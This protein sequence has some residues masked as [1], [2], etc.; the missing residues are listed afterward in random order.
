MDLINITA[1]DREPIHIPGAI[2][3]HGLLLVADRASLSVNMAAGDIEGRLGAGD[4]LFRPL[5]DFIGVALAARAAGAPEGPA[6]LFLGRIETAGAERLDVSVHATADALFVEFEPASTDPS[7]AAFVLSELEAA[8][9][10]FQNTDNIQELC[11]VAAKKFRALTGFDRVMVYRFLDDESGRVVAESRR[12]DLGSFLHHHFP[13]SDIPRQARALYVRNLV[14]TIPTIDYQAAPLRPPG[15]AA[16]LDM[17]DCALRSVSP[18]HLQYLR[19]MGV[20]ASASVSIVTGGRLWGLIACHNM[21]PLGL[22]HDARSVCRALAVALAQQIKAR[23]ERETYREQMRLTN[24]SAGLVEVLAREGPLHE[25]VSNHLAELARMLRSDGVAILRGSDLIASGE[26]PK[27]QEISAL[28]RWIASRGKTS[29]S[30]DR[31]AQLYPEAA[32]YRARAS[33]VAA[34]VL[35]FEEPWLILWFRAEKIEIVKWAGNPHKDAQAGAAGELTPRASFEMWSETVL[36]RARDWSLAEIEAAGR[37]A[38][39][40]LEARQNWRVRDLNRRLTD[41]L[42]DKDLLLEQKQYLIGEVNH[43]VQNSLQLV[44][45]FLTLQGMQSQ[46]ANL[47]GSIDEANRRIGAVALLHR[48]LYRGDQI[49]IVELS[50]YFEEL[51]ADAIVALGSGWAEHITLDLAP[52]S[53]ST[54]QAVVLGLILTEL[55]INANKYAYGG[56]PGPVALKLGEEHGRLRLVLSDKGAGKGPAARKGFGARMLEALVS[57]LGGELTYEDNK[58]GLR[59]TLSAPLRGPA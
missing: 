19:N 40:V 31:L 15:P 34:A 5:S 37:L 4:W 51:V 14:R 30:T 52:V 42:K 12:E 54:D 1:C 33:G 26:G 46:D 17:S 22:P 21:Q 13:A 55:L 23:E 48:R 7:P 35:S 39:A 38:S 25:A 2:Q 58:P 20:C 24:L 28:A 36:G 50:R 41:T 10:E 32:A 45:S 49:E 56:A 47:R 11:D 44:S 59:V 53:A 27:N 29:F 57:Q 18:I 9:T 16:A 3:P 8:T 6:G 43:R